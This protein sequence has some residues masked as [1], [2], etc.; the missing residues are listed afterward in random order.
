[1]RDQRYQDL[2]LQT[3]P[4]ATSAY[5]LHTTGYAFDVLRSYRN[6]RAA[7]AFQFMLDRLAGAQPD[8]LGARAGGDPRHGL[9]RRAQARGPPP[10]AAGR[11]ES[12]RM[13]ES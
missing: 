1:M 12:G 5:S 7:D 9:E 10:A 6:R 11:V 8:R 2:L 3:N 4:E 13:E